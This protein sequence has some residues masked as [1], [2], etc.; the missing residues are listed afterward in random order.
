MV[1]SQIARVEV[2]AAIWGKQRAGALTVSEARELTA[3]FEA[4]WFGSDQ[5]SPRF[6]AVALTAGVLDEAAR[7]CAV[8]RLRAYDGVQLACA[9]AAR[10]A[11]PECEVLAAFDD[12]LR[13]AAASE[14]FALLPT[15]EG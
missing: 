3:A 14:G 9:L 12:A 11:E 5:A 2:P 1:V 8:H 13:S 4:D 7:L 15:V 10:A 6:A